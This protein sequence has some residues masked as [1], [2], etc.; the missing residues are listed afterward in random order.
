MYTRAK[1]TCRGTGDWLN[2][3]SFGFSA[4]VFDTKA[5]DKGKFGNG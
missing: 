2:A 3:L 5:Q 4:C 1:G